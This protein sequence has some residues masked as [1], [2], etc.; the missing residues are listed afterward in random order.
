MRCSRSRRRCSTTVS[1]ALSA[2]LFER[3]A[4]DEIQRCSRLTPRRATVIRGTGARGRGDEPRGVVRH[5]VYG[6]PDR[7][8]AAARV[9]DRHGPS[10]ALAGPQPV[11]P[12]RF[13]PRVRPGCTRERRGGS[14]AGE[15]D[16]VAENPTAIAPSLIREDGL[17]KLW[18][19]TDSTFRR[20]KTNMYMDLIA[21][22]AYAAPAAACLTRLFFRLVTDELTEFAYPAECA[23]VA[24][25]VSNSTLGLRLMVGGY[26]HKLPLLLTRVLSKLA[27]PTLDPERFAMQRDLQLK[28]YANFFKGRLPSLGARPAALPAPTRRLGRA[29]APST[30]ARWRDDDSLRPAGL[31]RQT[32]AAGG[33]GVKCA[34]SRWIIPRGRAATLRSPL[35]RAGTPTSPL[36]VPSAAATRASAPRA[37]RPQVRHV[38]PAR[39]FAMAS[40]RVP[41]LYPLGR[42]LA[43]GAA[44][45]WSTS[46]SSACTCRCSC[47][48]HGRG[49]C[50]S[51]HRRGGDGRLAR[52]GPLAAALPALLQLPPTRGRVPRAPL[53]SRAPP[54]SSQRGR[55]TAPSVAC[56]P[57]STR[58]RSRSTSSCS[59]RSSRIRRTRRCARA[60]RLR[61]ISASVRP[62]RPGLRH[63]ESAS[64]TQYPRRR[65]SRPAGALEG[66]S[67]EE[68]ATKGVHRRGEAEAQDLRRS[69][70]STGTRSRRA[71]RLPS[72]ID[73]KLVE[74]ARRRT[75]R[76]LAA[77]ST[78]GARAA[79]A[80]HQVYAALPLPAKV[81]G[82][83]WAG[84]ALSPTSTKCS[85]IRLSA[86]SPPRRAATRKP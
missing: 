49:A 69:R 50:G 58:A 3:W 57:A 64:P 54:A 51:S 55:G 36:A 10:A 24:Y 26:Q 45:S 32:R 60:G 53:R 20:P 39:V 27:K 44:S 75:C 29:P 15:A 71:L 12:D 84:D 43:R 70:P 35:A 2:P 8:R 48:Q 17:A 77:T 62:R 85:S 74:R 67:E 34:T 18:H 4:P 33:N 19:K 25:N 16:A 80:V 11:H 63:R 65:S 31:H 72:S 30:Y 7:A 41:R 23:G 56:R 14:A 52:R 66:L 46:C 21:P 6:R 47:T 9:R 78:R 73:A 59:R 40:A 5:R 37:A 28:E 82:R 38:P 83:E 68:F 79:Q 76:L 86:A 22:A 61:A 42:V 1:L 13:C 81:E